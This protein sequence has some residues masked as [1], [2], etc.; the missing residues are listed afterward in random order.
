[1]SKEILKKWIAFA[2]ADLDAACRLFESPRPTARTYLL[3]LWHCQQCVEK[4]LKMVIIS[5]NK[6]LKKIHDLVHLSNLAELKLSQE[7]ELF[8]KDLNEFYLRSRYPDL[9]YKPLPK[10]SKNITQKYLNKTKKIFLWLQKQ[11]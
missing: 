8:L 6:E 3:V 4:M 2:S 9:K 5:K 10:P 7:N 1:M 11:I